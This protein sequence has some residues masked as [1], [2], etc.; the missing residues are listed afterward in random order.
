MTKMLMKQ[1]FY[2]HY[3]TY[4]GLRIPDYAKQHIDGGAMD[5]SVSSGSVLQ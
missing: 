3:D 2:R 4:M 5:G 1:L